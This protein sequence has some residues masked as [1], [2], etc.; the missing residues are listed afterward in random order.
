MYF[1][2]VDEKKTQINEST[3]LYNYLSDAAEEGSGKQNS[4]GGAG[5]GLDEPHWAGW[6]QDMAWVRLALDCSG[7]DVGQQVWECW[8]AGE[9]VH[10]LEW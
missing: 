9:G 10:E 7:W 6:N 4:T 2:N 5:T 1:I 3:H 8:T